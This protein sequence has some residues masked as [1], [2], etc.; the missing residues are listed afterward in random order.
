MRK[1][2]I[3]RFPVFK[4]IYFSYSLD[5]LLNAVRYLSLWIVSQFSS[6]RD[7]N[8]IYIMVLFRGWNEIMFW[9]RYANT[10]IIIIVL[11][12]SLSHS[13]YAF[14]YRVLL[15]TF[16]C[17]TLHCIISTSNACN[18][19]SISPWKK[20]GVTTL[21]IHESHVYNGSISEAN[22]RVRGVSFSCSIPHLRNKSWLLG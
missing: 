15:R 21:L 13:W 20:R 16:F 17:I 2:R 14:H 1:C 4:K 18:L 7:N 8:N 3:L 6:N 22:G 9:Q 12:W 11:I 10:L 19:N 5:W